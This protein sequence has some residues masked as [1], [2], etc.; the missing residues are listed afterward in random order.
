M[1]SPRIIYIAGY[2]RSGSTIVDMILNGADNALSTGELTYLHEDAGKPGRHCTCGECYSACP[3]YGPW[4]AQRPSEEG[5]LVRSIEGRSGLERLLAG[6]LSKQIASSYRDYAT[7]LFTHLQAQSGSDVI[8]DSSKSAKDAA[9]RPIALHRLAGLDVKIL[10]LTRDPR[11]TV[12]SYLDRGSNWV[13]E[14]HRAPKLLESWRPIVGWTLA[15]RVAAQVGIAVGPERYLHVRLEDLLQ[16]PSEILA[17]IGRFAGLDLGKV[18]QRVL[19]NEP[20]LAGH[21]VGGNRTRLKPQ[22]IELHSDPP[23]PI[24]LGHALA[25]RIV[26]GKTARQFGYG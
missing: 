12:R 16:N 2:S 9:G 22:Q 8:V 24:P 1:N 5:D 11:S 20:F 19:A 14:G 6:G 13:L 3:I 23:L 4:L 15:N 25:L 10:H 26:G 18:T 7:S 21:N 17:R